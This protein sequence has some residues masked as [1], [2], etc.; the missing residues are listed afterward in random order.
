MPWITASE[1]TA[2]EQS[3]SVTADLAGLL[4]EHG[5]GV[6]TVIIWGSIDGEDVV[7]SQYSIF[8]GIFGPES[9]N[10]TD[11]AGFAVVSAGGYHTCGVQDGRLRR[12]LGK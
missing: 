8:H 9:D 1:M 4:D 3:F 2:R 12:M 6:Y 7:I 11:Q 10:S 5:D